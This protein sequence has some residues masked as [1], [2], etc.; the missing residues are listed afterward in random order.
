MRAGGWKKECGL[1]T[2][3]NTETIHE[4]GRGKYRYVGVVVR[5]SIIMD[6]KRKRRER[7]EWKRW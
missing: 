6:E 5:L 3:V 4:R 7:G 1:C 2:Y